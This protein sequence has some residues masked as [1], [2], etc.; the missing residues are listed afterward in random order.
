MPAQQVEHHW[1]GLV[2]VAGR[3]DPIAEHAGEMFDGGDQAHSLDQPP[4]LQAPAE[5]VVADWQF[6]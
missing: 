3:D 4:M 2:E 6:A 1:V 5:R